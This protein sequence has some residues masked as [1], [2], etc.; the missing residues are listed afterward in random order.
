MSSLLLSQGDIVTRGEPQST[1]WARDR[2][3]WKSMNTFTF[4]CTVSQ[5]LSGM[6]KTENVKLAV[7]SS[8]TTKCRDGGTGRR[9]GLKIRRP[10]GLGGSTPPPGTNCKSRVG[11]GPRIHKGLP[12]SRG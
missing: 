6:K 10:S 1:P 8:T 5:S 7:E 3:L 12:K 11:R 4:T 9:S 2:D